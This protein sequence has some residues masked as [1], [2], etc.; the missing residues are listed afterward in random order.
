MKRRFVL[1]RYPVSAKV[2]M[3]PNQ[4]N[5]NR[6]NDPVGPEPR[7]GGAPHLTTADCEELDDWSAEVGWETDY[8]QLGRGR[9]DA[10][11]EMGLCPELKVVNQY[12]NRATLTTGVPPTGYV[13]LLLPLNQRDRGVCQGREMKENE[14]VIACPDSR[15][16][17]RTPDDFR[18]LSMHIPEARL[19]V[20]LRDMPNVDADGLLAETRPIKLTGDHVR[21][22]TWLSQ[23]VIDTTHCVAGP[24]VPD[25]YRQEL[26]EHFVTTVV[27]GLTGPDERQPG[28]LARENRVKYVTAARDFIE[29][30]LKQ[31]LGLET[32][33]QETDVSPRTL[34]YAFRE[35]FDT[36]PLQYIKIRRLNA[37]RH[38]LLTAD[39][40]SL[41]VTEVAMQCGFSHL[42]YF[43]RDYNTL[44]GEFPSTTL[45]AHLMRHALIDH[46][47]ATLAE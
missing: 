9:F 2:E 25:L 7:P 6:S 27:A 18:L 38:C 45:Q 14:A 35:V 21:R 26:E 3:Q 36:S 28:L 19:R 15:V 23:Q 41:T 24:A 46:P 39:D 44:F 11:F 12:C 32:L 22:L 10:W 8:R 16:V 37:A 29:A 33:A 20:A 4:R 5:T 47:S 30:N 17:Y 13:P 43:A 1:S 31:P 34:E 40:A 42:S